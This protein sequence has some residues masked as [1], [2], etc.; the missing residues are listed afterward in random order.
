MEL[1]QLEMTRGRM[2]ILDTVDAH[3]GTY[4]SKEWVQKNILKQ[5][6][7]E[8]KEIARAQIRKEE[9]AG[10]TVVSPAGLGDQ[11]MEPE[12]EAPMNNNAASQEE[13]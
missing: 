10:E 6:E 4:I 5:D 1:Q 7:Q 3:V 12:E 11:P 13:Q 9:G 2:D 8:I